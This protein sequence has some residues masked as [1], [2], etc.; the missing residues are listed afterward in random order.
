MQTVAAMLTESENLSIPTWCVY[1][2]S[3]ICSGFHLAMLAE[4][5]NYSI[6][7]FPRSIDGEIEEERLQF[8]IP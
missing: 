6:A 3:S 1:L 4:S 8:S 5:E 7:I 2:Q